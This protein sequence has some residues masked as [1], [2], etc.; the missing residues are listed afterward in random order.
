MKAIFLTDRTKEVARVYDPAARERIREWVKPDETVYTKK[1]VLSGKRDFRDVE[2]VFSTWGMPHFSPE[3]IVTYLP[4][5]RF[6]FYAAGSVQGFAKPFLDRGVRIFNA[7]AAN[8]VPVAEYAVAQIILANKGFFGAAGLAKQGR[9]PEGRQF[10]E[11]C[12]GNYG[13]KVGIIG[14]GTIGRMVAERLQPYGVEVLAYD[15]FLPK[16]QADALGIRQVSLE[17]LF[18]Q[19]HVVSNHLADNAATR[20]MLNGSLFEKMPKNAVFLNTGRGAQVVEADL[21]AVL[22]NRPDL[23]AVLDV[24]FPEPPLAESPFYT[25]KN[26]ILTPHIAGSSGR[27]VAR[28]AAYMAE[29][30]ERV[31]KGD[32]PHFEVTA[33]MLATM[34]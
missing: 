27:E 3:E 9:Y 19:C 31:I 33:D 32:R 17:E 2:A 4:N 1:D 11:A 16:E 21:C 20:G 23:T 6:I 13:A 14:V 18:S 24:T 7:S 34:A 30:C 15:A 28:M 12:P 26:C 5:L 25:L 8:A 10:C 29:E 22:S